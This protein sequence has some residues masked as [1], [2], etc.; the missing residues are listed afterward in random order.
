VLE[1]KFN[2][3]AAFFSLYGYQTFIFKQLHI[4]SSL[5][6]VIKLVFPSLREQAKIASFF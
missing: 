2:P 6:Q 5:F 3:F 1:L 4:K